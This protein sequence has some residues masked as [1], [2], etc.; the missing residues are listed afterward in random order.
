M[1]ENT[2]KDR[3]DMLRT[4]DG[5]RSARRG[6]VR[7][8]PEDL[9][10]VKDFLND[11][12]RDQLKDLEARLKPKTPLPQFSN[13]DACFLIWMSG[14][15]AGANLDKDGERGERIFA[16]CREIRD[17]LMAQGANAS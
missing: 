3:A 5:S 10:E 7:M 16:R 2:V 17:K 12:I 6:P 13:D 1:S 15:T 14:F 8:A 9:S 11:Q 4:G